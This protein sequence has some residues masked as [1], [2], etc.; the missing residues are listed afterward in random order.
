MGSFLVSFGVIVAFSFI[1]G[2]LIA[3]VLEDWTDL[4]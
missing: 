1:G 4:M 2:S 3:K